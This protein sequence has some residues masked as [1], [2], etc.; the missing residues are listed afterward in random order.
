MTLQARHTVESVRRSVRFYIPVDVA[1]DS[2][3]PFGGGDDFVARVSRHEA[4]VLTPPNCQ[5]T[6]FEVPPIDEDLRLTNNS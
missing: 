6:T 5:Q 2:T 3:F 4:V 1:V